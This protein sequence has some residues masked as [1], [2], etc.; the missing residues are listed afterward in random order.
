MRKL[1]EQIKGLRLNSE[2]LVRDFVTESDE[3]RTRAEGIVIGASQAGVYLHDDELIA[4]VT[5]EV[6]V[7][8]VVERIK[9][10][11]STHYHGNKV[12]TTDI[13]N[14]KRSIQREMI[15]ATGSGVPPSR[16]LDQA[17]ASAD[18]PPWLGER[19]E[20]VGQGTDPAIDTAQ[21]KLKAARA[22]ELDAK[23]KLAEQVF[24]M[25]IQSA[26]TVRDF[27]T[28]HDEI[29]TQVQAVIAGATA[30]TPTRLS[31]ISQRRRVRGRI[32]NWISLISF[33]L[34]IRPQLHNS[35]EINSRYSYRS[36]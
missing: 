7:E 31:T 21:G 34:N 33:S 5:M 12:T 11:H 35:I 19:I 30:D 13:T 36:M 1:L 3:I 15:Q 23:R 22:A 9:E 29:A 18:M 26:T 24:G 8:K 20:A 14:V 17:R 4:D 28:Q 25:Q 2:T 32:F 27:V 6:P 10:L 16:F